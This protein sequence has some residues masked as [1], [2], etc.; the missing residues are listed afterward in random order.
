MS[1]FFSL[2]SHLMSL[3]KTLF[4][5][6]FPLLFPF[7]VHHIC[8]PLPGALSLL[9]TNPSPYGNF[10]PSHLCCGTTYHSPHYQLPHYYAIRQE[11]EKIESGGKHAYLS[12]RTCPGD[13]R[14]PTLHDSYLVSIIN[15]SAL[16]EAFRCLL[17]FFF[18]FFF[19]LRPLG[20]FSRTETI[21]DH[22]TV[23]LQDSAFIPVHSRDR[24]PT[25]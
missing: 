12:C 21:C 15:A 22:N 6:S 10:H 16:R 2:S 20:F 8:P 13:P 9:F 23:A 1:L 18:L 19:F 3:P 7:F 17:D 14:Q 5:P 11:R 25:R 4:S 24:R